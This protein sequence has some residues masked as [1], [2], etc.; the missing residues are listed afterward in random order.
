MIENEISILYVWQI[1][2]LPMYTKNIHQTF[3]MYRQLQ[4]VVSFGNN[5]YNFKVQIG[6]VYSRYDWKVR[7]YDGIGN[8]QYKQLV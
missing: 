4:N 6:M 5:V 8:G 2:S 1:M 3:T 7:T